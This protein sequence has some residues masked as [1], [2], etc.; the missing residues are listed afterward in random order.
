MKYQVLYINTAF[1]LKKNFA[2]ID[3]C[4]RSESGSIKNKHH[5][6]ANPDFCQAEKKEATLSGNSR[7]LIIWMI[8]IYMWH[9]SRPALTFC[10]DERRFSSIEKKN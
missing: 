7:T 3:H 6:V 2:F 5:S 4:R 8:R 10:V 9:L 1:T